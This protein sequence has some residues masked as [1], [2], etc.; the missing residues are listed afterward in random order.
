MFIIDYLRQYQGQ[1]LYYCPNPGNAGDALIA[2]ATFVLFKKLNLDINIISLDNVPNLTDQIVIYGGGGNFI[3]IYD[4][5]LKFCRQYHTQV[6]KLIILPHTIEDTEL[7]PEFG[8]NVD[9][10]C[11][12]R[13]SYEHVQQIANKVNAYLCPD[14]VL[15]LTSA[16]ISD[17][18]ATEFIFSHTLTLNLQQKLLEFELLKHRH[19]ELRRQYSQKPLILHCFRTDLEKTAISIPENNVDLSLAVPNFLSFID[20]HPEWLGYS[21]KELFNFILHYDVVVTNRLHVAM[22]ACLLNKSVQLYPNNY[23]KVRAVYEY[24]LGTR[25]FP[26]LQWMYD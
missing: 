20:T 24:S 8:S 19:T 23:W 18:L 25:F 14:L 7:L 15:N 13:Q 2:Y 1:N 12:E 9:I 6:K 22:V 3:P 4:D 10:L 26:K 17:L 21:V 5:C 16:E 11:R